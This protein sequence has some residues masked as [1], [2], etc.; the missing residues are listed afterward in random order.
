MAI[1]T[2]HKDQRSYKMKKSNSKVLNFFKNN[3]VYLIFALCIVAVGLSITLMLLNRTPDV[4]V[5]QPPQDQIVVDK[6]NDDEVNVDDILPPEQSE[7]VVKPV[8]FVMPVESSTSIGEYSEQMVFNSTLGRFSAHLAVDFFAPEG[9]K[10]LAVYDGTIESVTTE[11]LTGTTI[12]ID[13][14]NGLKTVYNSLADG[15]SVTVGQTVKSGDVIGEVSLS[16][17][18][19][20]K[21]G[22]HLHFQV[23]ENDEIIDPAKYLT[24]NEK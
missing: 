15:D 3:A 14:G 17:K 6:P 24:F 23:I 16:N 22:A 8:V 7:P 19:E 4:Q 5:Q 18:Q 2:V 11:F 9:T 10:V 1:T 13:H 21:E 12:T 20:Y